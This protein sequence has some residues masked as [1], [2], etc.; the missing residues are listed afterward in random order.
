VAWIEDVAT[1]FAPDAKLLQITRAYAQ[2]NPGVGEDVIFGVLEKLRKITNNYVG[3]IELADDLA[4]E[5]VAEIF[6]RVNSAGTE[7][8]QADFAMSKIAVN[9]TYGGNML[10][11]A[12]DYFCHLAVAP[13]FL[14]RIE[15]GDKAFAASEFLPQ[16]RWLK[17]TNDD[18]Y[19]PTYTDY[20]RG[21]GRRRAVLW[22]GP[23]VRV[24]VRVARRVH[25]DDVGGPGV[26][27]RRAADAGSVGHAGGAGIGVHVAPEVYDGW[28]AYDVGWLGLTSSRARR[29]FPDSPPMGP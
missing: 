1:I 22:A 18:I 15:R 17:D 27:A 20:G 23:P 26:C 28:A 24:S 19:D 25:A 10:R 21:R 5:T 11:K 16:M 2:A 3:V 7:L 9:E 8:S 13:E 4:T 29:R 12:I 14:A 6:I